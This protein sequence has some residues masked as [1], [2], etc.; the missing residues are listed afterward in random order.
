MKKRE[1]KETTSL[2]YLVL[3]LLSCEVER[4]L[5]ALLCCC[6]P[7]L[8]LKLARACASAAA[9]AAAQTP[10]CVWLGWWLVSVSAR[11]PSWGGR[12]AVPALLRP[13]AKLQA[14]GD[15]ALPRDAAEEENRRR[16]PPPL[17][18]ARPRAFSRFGHRHATIPSPRATDVAVG[19][20]WAA[21][22]LACL[23]SQP[24]TN[25]NNPP[26][27]APLRPA[28]AAPHRRRTGSRCAVVTGSTPDSSVGEPWRWR[29]AAAARA[30]R[31]HPPDRRG[32]AA[33]P[34]ARAMKE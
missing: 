1:W 28:S 22:S 6:A 5:L 13:E 24:T 16:S 9:A 25:T 3:S 27:S 18:P 31:P 8:P 33:I 20:R 4:G 12:P 29:T 14:D 34:L 10:K 7:F 23:A 19:S 15:E 21:A 17:S 30:R 2:F 32:P 26:C 11:S